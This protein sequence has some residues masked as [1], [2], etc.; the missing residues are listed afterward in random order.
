[1][2]KTSYPKK[3]ENRQG[4]SYDKGKTYKKA[5]YNPGLVPRGS[6]A[7]DKAAGALKRMRDGQSTDSNN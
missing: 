1:M 4:I 7:F 2:A 6:G 5:G 3:G